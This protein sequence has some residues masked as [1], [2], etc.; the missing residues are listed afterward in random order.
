MNEAATHEMK[1]PSCGFAGEFVRASPRFLVFDVWHWLVERNTARRTL[2]CPKCGTKVT[3]TAGRSA[4]IA[5]RYTPSH[6]S[7]GKRVF[8]ILLSLGLIGYGLLG[9]LADDL[10]LPGSGPGIHLYGTPALLMCIAFICAAG[11]LLSV[12]IDH[13]D[14]RDNERY[15][16][17]F[18]RLGRFAG[19]TFFGLSL[20]LH[21]YQSLTK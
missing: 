9:L 7:F 6:I 15:Y 18:A 20:A 14:K 12:V 21:V 17:L 2:V 5:M 19:W 1:C 13:Y 10:Y 16:R 4:R 3:L 8:G 11:V